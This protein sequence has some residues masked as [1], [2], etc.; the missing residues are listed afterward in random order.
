MFTSRWSVV[1]LLFRLF[2]SVNSSPVPIYTPAPTHPLQISPPTPSP[3]ILPSLPTS[4]P[5]STPP[6]SPHFSSDPGESAKSVLCPLTVSPSILV[7]RFK[8]PVKVNCSVPAMSFSAL[9]WEVSLA[10]PEL[11]TEHF[12]VWSVD[13]MTDWSVKPACF[14]LVEQG[15]Q[16]Q[17]D[18]SLIVYKPPDNVSISVDNHTGSM[19]E[20]RQ[21]TLLC[22]V[23]NVAP[24][25]NVTVTFYKEQTPLGQ[26]QSS[27]TTKTPVTEIFSWNICPKKEDDGVRYWC[28]AKLE[29]G[30]EGPQ[31]PPVAIS[32]N[33]SARVHFGP[34]FA[35]PTRMWIREGESLGCE[36]GGNPPPLVI[37]Y[38]DGEVVD[39]PSH[40]N[41]THAGKYTV[42]AEGFLGKKNFT[43]EVEVLPGSGTANSF[44]R[45]FLFGVLLIQTT[46]WL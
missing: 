16:C 29:L 17:L 4:S 12:L 24:V 2:S 1:F 13:S 40:S 41:L 3:T 9:G 26:V 38:K 27:N 30:P 19:I 6:P 10:K 45:H 23:Y 39:L 25:E 21:Y 37:W 15:G 34:Q 32:Q 22:T 31:N 20:G 35:C 11:T 36:V 7:V 18:L 42:W 28:E 44:N 33:L 8:D 5:L 43:M 46:Y 14:A